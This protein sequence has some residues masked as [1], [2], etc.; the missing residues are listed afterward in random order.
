MKTRKTRI[1]VLGLGLAALAPWAGA[2]A[3]ERAADMFRN[4]TA[5]APDRLDLS[6]EAFAAAD[7]TASPAG[8]GQGTSA[9][10]KGHDGLELGLGP[11][12]SELDD[13]N[14][15]KDLQNPVAD[16]ISVPMENRVDV[17]PGNSWRYT[18][19]LQPVIPFELSSD[20][21]V[22]SR[23][24]L[25]IVC[26]QRP[27][28]ENPAGAGSRLG[29]I[30]DITQSFFFAPKQAVD[31]W[32]F[33]AG[34]VLRL[35]SASRDFM[36]DGRWGAG[37]TAVVLRQDGSWTYGMLANH[38]WSFAGW[39]P[40]NVNATLINPFLAYTTDSL[41][42]IGV[43]ADATYDWVHN[44]WAM[45][46]DLTVSQLFRIGEVPVQMGL[47]GRA[48]VLRPDGGPSWG[49]VLTVTLMF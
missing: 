31:G 33:G 28:A 15:A 35:P 2:L 3:A 1:A 38:I 39:G 11:N 10:A 9:L 23:T 24:L 41:T 19:T 27:D 46:V 42:T 18:L 20:W 37:P 44:Q 47:G 4:G 17:G 30:G 43:G 34:P 29:G 49:T 14:L 8:G 40:Q 26:A 6:I 48:Y 21:M 45:P 5:Y 16:V 12:A 22:V 25:P 32:I 36:G 7:E 13:A